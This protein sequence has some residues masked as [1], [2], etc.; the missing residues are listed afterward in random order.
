MP[1]FQVKFKAMRCGIAKT[2]QLHK[3]QDESTFSCFNF[4]FEQRWVRGNVMKFLF[5]KFLRW[6]A[7]K[8]GSLA[9]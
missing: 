9:L 6:Q 8:L 2:D 1:V 4:I 3:S 5:Y 7:S